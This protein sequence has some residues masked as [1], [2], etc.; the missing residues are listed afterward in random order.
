ML[1][2]KTWHL[3]SNQ[4]ILNPGSTFNYFVGIVF[5]FMTSLLQW[6]P[7][8]LAGWASSTFRLLFLSLLGFTAW[9]RSFPGEQ[10][11][12]TF[13]LSVLFFSVM[14]AYY[15]HCKGEEISVRAKETQKRF[16]L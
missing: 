5:R 7:S 2:T 8:I 14:Y 12:A 15:M 16:L 4:G 13:S 6:L 3:I 11:A 10:F 9:I 1:G